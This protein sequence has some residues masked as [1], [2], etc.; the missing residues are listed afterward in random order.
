MTDVASS[1]P[2]LDVEAGNTFTV[3]LSDPAA[4][5]ESMVVHINQEEPDE[6]LAVSS[7]PPIPAYGPDAI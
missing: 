2:Q 3:T 6:P 7:L 4:V 5:I 1:L